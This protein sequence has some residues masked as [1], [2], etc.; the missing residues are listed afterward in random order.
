MTFLKK[1]NENLK[2]VSD[3]IVG[4]L[5]ETSPQTTA[6]TQRLWSFGKPE[7]YKNTTKSQHL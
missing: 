2:N 6:N 7:I 4:F 3:S 1:L 5:D